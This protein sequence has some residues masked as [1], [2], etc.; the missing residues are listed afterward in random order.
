M[1]KIIFRGFLL[2]A[3]FLFCGM[4]NAQQTVSG[5][6]TDA[7]GPLPG[8][9]V[10]IK[11]TSTGTTTDFDGNYT[12]NDVPIDATLVFSF[13]GYVSQEMK[14]SGRSTIDVNLETDASELDEVVLIG[15]G[16]TTIRDATGAVS[17][18]TAEEFNKGNIASPE[19]LIQGKTAGVQITQASGEPGAGVAL[20][21]RGTTSVRSNNN[22]LFVVD[23]VPLSGDD[24]SV[25]S[26]DLGVGS[27]SARNPLNFLNPSDIESISVLKDA[28]ATAIYGSRGANGVVIIQT[29]SG[30]GAQGGAFTYDGS[31]S[32]ASPANTYDLLNRDQFLQGIADLGGNPDDVD[33]GADTDFQDE[34]FR[35]AFSQNHTLSYM[36][37][38][39]SGNVR[40]SL[41]Y[42][43]INGIVE[44]SELERLTGRL[45]INQ[46]FLDDRLNLALQATYSKVDDKAVPIAN[47]PGAAGDLLAATY[48]TNPTFPADVTFDPGGGNLNPLQLLQYTDDITETDRVLLNFSAD[49]DILQ[50]LNAKVT[51]GYDRSDSEKTVAYSSDILGLTNGVP[52]NGR[53]LLDDRTL[54]NTL[55]EFVVNYDKEFGDSNLSALA[56]YSYQKFDREGVYGSG[57]GFQTS[58]TQEMI[59]LFRG[60][61]NNIRN[62][63]DGTYQTFG[64]GPNGGQLTRLFPEEQSNVAFNAP[65][66]N[67]NSVTGGI[68]ENYDE[69][70][71]FFTR[72]NY[73]IADKYLFT[74]TMRADG[75]SKF[76][77][78]EKYGYFPSGAFA[79]KIDQEDF[80]SDPISTLKLRL[81]YGVTGNQDGLG[82]GNF[83]IRRNANGYGIDNGGNV[84]G[85]G[86]S[87]AG[88][89]NPDLKW[90]STT[91]T[92]LGVDFGFAQDR[93]SGSLDLYYKD[94]K[95][96]LLLVQNAQPSPAPFSFQNIDGNLINK[97]IEFALDY[98]VFDTDDFFWN[99][100]FNI[101]YNE[102]ELQNFDGQIQSAQ[103][104]G[105]GLTGAFSQ[106]LVENRPLFSYYL[107]EFGGFDE[108]GISIYP[109]GDQQEF[110][111]KSA[112]PTTN[113]GI[114]TRATYKN[115]DASLF[116]A[117]Q[118]GFY[119]YNN[120]ANALFTAGNLN[121]GRNVTQ[122]VLTNGESRLNAPDVS[123]RFLEKGD[124]V[125]LQNASLGYTFELGD[126]ALLDDLR[127]YVNGQNLFLITDY[128][129][130]DPE[131]STQTPLNGLPTAGIDNTS[132][133]RARTF[134]FGVNAKF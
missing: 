67:L 30:R 10:A 18:V 11:G 13:V 22:P 64:V 91:Q 4:T 24:T 12:L 85:G 119:V 39:Q 44:R 46:R 47:A 106:L 130:L 41:G 123:T 109:N 75:S 43:D 59:G 31:L 9:T 114:N 128:S 58:N 25:G 60:D 34:V 57:F 54:T 126:D 94:T 107:R 101:S 90:E 8:A 40:V 102:N 72:I 74:V 86:F 21:I 55:L 16:T 99:F 125:R 112:L 61:F 93:L 32:V 70:Q 15:Y 29:K 6:V 97:G 110:V 49:Y 131:V 17:S 118:F 103:I 76:G 113:L 20:R 28:S 78:S 7:D 84:N 95:D 23:G 42:N 82:Y 89:S 62:S 120:T 48:Y 129:G 52:G 105:Q 77:P 37:S 27:S 80:I 68:F 71:S 1:K 69:L 3:V 73:T 81:G 117:G 127:L 65:S 111:D 33:F 50:N 116:F 121:T 35:T 79:W 122:D 66:L 104:S 56:G 124:F 19:E 132:Y 36:N 98:D 5:T 115:W 53:S 133:P 87:N 2:V 92:N 108:N 100:G 45:N 26:G 96:L 134:T 38:Y 83:T 88:F 63:I 51:L 14:V